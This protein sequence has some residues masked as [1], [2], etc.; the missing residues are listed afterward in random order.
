MSGSQ[1]LLQSSLFL[2][3]RNAPA[4][5]RDENGCVTAQPKAAKESSA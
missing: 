2:S 1:G 4:L 5:C 3:S